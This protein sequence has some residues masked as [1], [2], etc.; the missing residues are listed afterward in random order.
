MFYFKDFY[1]LE[2]ILNL[3]AYFKSNLNLVKKL[4]KRKKREQI[5]LKK[6]KNI[7]NNIIS[8]ESNKEGKND[9]LNLSSP[10]N[11]KYLTLNKKDKL[12]NIETKELDKFSNLNKKN[13]KNKKNLNNIFTINK[14]NSDKNQISNKSDII[15]NEKDNK[16]NKY[17][18]PYN[19]SE[20][21]IYEMFLK[22]NANSDSEL[23]ELDY[24]NAIKKDIRTY[25]QYYLSLLRTKHLFIFSFWP[26]FDYN[27][28]IIKIFLFKRQRHI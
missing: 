16:I 8:T 9:N 23:N 22:I 28:Q 10:V 5:K 21:Q 1:F 20:D 18:Y 24:K 12:S 25:F 13:N 15:N 14:L 17:K 19:M 11:S 3:I 27:S 6:I 26:S 4:I 2:K 7:E